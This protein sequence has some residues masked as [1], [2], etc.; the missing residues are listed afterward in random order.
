MEIL[1]DINIKLKNKKYDGKKS[2]KR[3]REKKKDEI[4][5]EHEEDEITG[6]RRIARKK[7]KMERQTLNL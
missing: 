6:G 1:N 5:G 4:A 3:K 7:R 2:Q